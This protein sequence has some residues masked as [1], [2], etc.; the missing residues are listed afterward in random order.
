MS[1]FLDNQNI[2][3]IGLSESEFLGLKKYKEIEIILKKFLLK[4]KFFIEKELTKKESENILNG[5][6]KMTEKDW[7]LLTILRLFDRQT[8]EHS[9]GTFIIVK[10]K[11]ENVLKNKT[12]LKEGIKNEV[13]DISIFYRACLFHDIGKITIPKLILKN[14]LGDK[15]W[16]LCFYKIIKKQKNKINFATKRY[17]KKH[18]IFHFVDKIAYADSPNE[19]LKILKT[20]KLRPVQ[21]IPLK[22][23]ISKKELKRL[24]KEY[25]IEGDVTLM[26]VMSLHKKESYNILYNLGYKK[27]ALIAGSHGVGGQ[28]ENINISKAYSSIRIGSRM[29]DIVDLIHLADVQEALGSDRYYHKSFTKLKIISVLVSDVERGI[30]D[31]SV[32]Y[33]WI[34][35]EFEKLKKDKSFQDQIKKIEKKLENLDDKE[36]DIVDDLRLIKNFIESICLIVH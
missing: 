15:D 25:G 30:I 31:K 9:L 26:E 29:S 5:Y 6:I 34:G 14:S 1:N 32:A 33:I 8:F 20:K 28:G 24:K 23:G 13:G 3:K 22:Y 21:V 11:I 19:I 2:S 16:S 17:F 35:D 10:D 7:D 18:S 4:G 36:K 27:E 12:M